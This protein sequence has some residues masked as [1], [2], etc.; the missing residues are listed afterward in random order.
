MLSLETL[1]QSHCTPLTK[2]SKAMVIPTIESHLSL[3]PAW[4]A[5][6]D[7]KAIEREITFKNHHYV[8]GFLNALAYL[9]HQQDYYPTI[10]YRYNKVNITLRT[11]AVNGVTHNDM[12][13]AAKIERLLTP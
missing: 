10:R 9:C 2:D 4:Q 12:I 11:E 8:M 13:M 5:T 7:Y 3:L 1:A 6:F